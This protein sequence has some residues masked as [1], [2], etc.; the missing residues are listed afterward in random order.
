MSKRWWF[1]LLH[2]SFPSASTRCL[3]STCWELILV[4]AV[5]APPRWGTQG[6]LGSP[7]TSTPSGGSGESPQER[8]HWKPVC[9]CFQGRLG[10]IWAREVLQ[11][12]GIYRIPAPIPSNKCPSAHLRHVNSMGQHHIA[13]QKLEEWGS[14]SV[15]SL[16]QSSSYKRGLQAAMEA[17]RLCDHT[18]TGTFQV[19]ICHLSFQFSGENRKIHPA[20]PPQPLH[21]S[22][23]P[24]G[25]AFLLPQPQAMIQGKTSPGGP[26]VCFLMLAES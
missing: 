16:C 19:A 7:A 25:R 4:M 23:G 12:L 17:P 9:F 5:K 1:F 20:S 8:L 24:P 26:T 18:L 11:D 2:K 21:C 10:E 13:I 3:L 14:G 15:F 22:L 6:R